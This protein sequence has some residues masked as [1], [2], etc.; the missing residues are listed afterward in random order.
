MKKLRASASVH[1]APPGKGKGK[2]RKGDRRVSLVHDASDRGNCLH[3]RFTEA[4]PA[5]FERFEHQFEAIPPAPGV[6]YLD[7]GA[8]DGL[9]ATDAIGAFAADVRLACLPHQEV[10]LLSVHDLD[11][12]LKSYGGYAEVHWGDESCLTVNNGYHSFHV[13]LDRD[14]A[15]IHLRGDTD[16][17][18]VFR[19][20]PGGHEYVLIDTGAGISCCGPS[21]KFLSNPSDPPAGLTLL[22]VNKSPLP[23]SKVGRFRLVFCEPEYRRCG[24]SFISIGYIEPPVAPDLVFTGIFF[25]SGRTPLMPV[26]HNVN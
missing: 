10:P 23:V 20:D 19:V 24:A 6:Y 12:S 17:Q 2:G 15:Y 26:I 25:V 14:G 3:A 7:D 5:S 9:D 4:A 16:C 1:S 18:Q 22:G 11:R 8:G 21:C 13:P